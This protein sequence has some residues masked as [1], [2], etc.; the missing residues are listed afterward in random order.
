MANLARANS[1]RRCLTILPSIAMLALLAVFLL[2]PQAPADLTPGGQ[3]ARDRYVTRAV[4]TL[5]DQQHLLRRPLDD[6]VSRRTLQTF[7]KQLDPMKVYFYQSDI[8][9]FMRSRELLDD[10]IRNGDISFG[11]QVFNRFLERVDERVAY[12]PE[13]LE[14]D[15]DF[16]VDEQMV[17]DPDVA[18]YPRTPA[19]AKD[20]WRRRIKY[21][22][23]LLK[24]DDSEDEPGF[25]KGEKATDRLLRR[26]NSYAKR[27]HQFKQDD[28]LEM[29]LTAM[30]SS[31]D[32]HTTY[33]S[34]TT[35]DNFNISMRLNLEGIG[36][37]LQLI[38]GY[39]VVGRVIPG[40]AADKEGELKP[41]DR[42][43]SVGQDEDGEMV[44]VMDMPLNDVVQLI[45][46]PAGTIV[47]LGIQREQGNENKSI[48]IVRDKIELRDSE[49]RPEVIEQGQKADGSPNRIGV[50][51][52]P[53]FYMDMSGA[54][55]GFTD[56]KSTTRD[57]RRIL[58]DFKSQGV[59]AVVLDLRFNGGGSLTEA[60]NL[61]GLFIDSGPVVQ[62]K[63]FENRVQQYDD[64]ER[65][66]AWDGP[67]VVLTNK[68]SASASEILAGAIQDYKRGIVIGDKTTH[69]KGTV[70]SLLDLSQQL[71]RGLANTPNLGAL[72]ITM[73]Q[74]YRPNG[75]STQKRGVEADIALPSTTAHMDIGEADLDYAVKFDTVNP[76]EFTKYNQVTS[77]I[78]SEL[79]SRSQVRRNESEDFAKLRKRIERYREQKERDFVTLNEEQFT[80]DRAELSVE[81]EDEKNFKEQDD[82]DDEVFP[83]NYYNDEILQ[84]TL[85]YIKLLDRVAIASQR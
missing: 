76:A 15:H 77:E 36:A 26:Y 56:F 41:E 66:M 45:R 14:L 71:F 12:V 34:P 21:D 10:Q 37:A 42:I 75:A 79:R 70:Q 22:L 55:Q 73:Q 49:A 82:A 67:L 58:E 85:D 39:T 83:R 38:D 29:Y 6:E 68:F 32:P 62:V 4:K 24:T 46:G 8:D 20:R 25:K 17:T 11:Y 9:E 27:M 33:M 60:I 81:K 30:T 54:K 3:Q 59:D 52:L 35:L 74:F 80:A 40:G 47:R 78:L 48:R 72:K 7:L 64:L 63:D 69:G 31:Y 13:L 65:G 84:I 53:S 51:N 5:L 57:V 23:L 43:V 44:D 61:T 1:R 2:V 18:K 16:D 28:L 50:I 19:E